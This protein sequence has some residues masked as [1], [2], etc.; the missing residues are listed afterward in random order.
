[1]LAPEVVARRAADNGVTLWA[2][3]DHDTIAGLGS[4]RAAANENGMAFVSGVEISIAWQGQQI[5]IVGLNFDEHD[6]RLLAGLASIRG[7]RIDRAQRMSESLAAVGIT[8]V[9]EQALT[10]AEDPDL[11][12]RAHFARCL[13]QRGLCPDVRSV[14]ERYLVPGRP[15]YVEHHWPDLADAIGWITAAGG[16]AVV[17]HPGRYR[18][19]AGA[20]RRF[21][22][23]FKSLGGHALEVVCGSHAPDVAALFARHVRH[24]GF[25]ASRGSDFHGPN[26]S[27]VDLGALPPL[28]DDLPPVWDGF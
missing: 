1:M 20:M 24:Y 22:D 18:L 12:S 23:E 19:S 15:G 28:P 11:I 3:T 8:G 9:F 2:L 5:H 6:H 14:F 21:L 27:Y 25:M 26:E 13:V 10:L 16:R 4:A 7:G 17:A